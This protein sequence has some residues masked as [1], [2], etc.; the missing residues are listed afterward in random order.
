MNHR[1]STMRNFLSMAVNLQLFKQ[2]QAAVCTRARRR[3]CMRVCVCVF[4]FVHSR[5]RASPHLHGFIVP[6]GVSLLDATQPNITNVINDV[7]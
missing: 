1:S 2:V 4:V 3:G 5:V 6:A 7:F